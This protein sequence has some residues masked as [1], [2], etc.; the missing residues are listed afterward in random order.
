MKT[1][2]GLT[3]YDKQSVDSTDLLC[4]WS[5]WIYNSTSYW[6]NLT[7]HV[8]QVE[9]CTKNLAKNGLMSFGGSQPPP[10]EF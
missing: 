5:F 2:L 4:E 8:A 10:D 7:N 9:N 1:V 6:P 3:H